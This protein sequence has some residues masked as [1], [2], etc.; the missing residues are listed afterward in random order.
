MKGSIKL[1]IVICLWALLGQATALAAAQERDPELVKQLKRAIAD[2]TSFGDRYEAEVWLADMSQRLKKRFPKPKDRFLFLK[3]VHGEA[4]RASLPPELVLAII[5]VESNFNQWAISRVGARGLMQIMPF[6]LK[7]IGRP[8][9]DLFTLQTNLRMGCTI[10]R[11][12]LDKENGNLIRALGRYNG[13]L[14]SF[15]YPDLV[16]TALRERWYRP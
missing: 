7:E 10:L 5:E 14:G 4:Q 11:H 16:L 1:T 12:Y 3:Y 6:W 2:T 15:R 9:D 8:G 13:S